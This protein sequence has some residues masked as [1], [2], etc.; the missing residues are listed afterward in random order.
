MAW[1]WLAYAGFTT[2]RPRTYDRRLQVLLRDLLEGLFCF[3]GLVL[4]GESGDQH[5]VVD[6]VHLLSISDM[7]SETSITIHN[8][9]NAR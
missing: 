5:V 3:L 8:Y 7:K 2:L 6:D 9:T 4:L 1:I